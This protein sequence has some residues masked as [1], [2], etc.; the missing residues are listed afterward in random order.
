MI[1][2]LLDMLSKKVSKI[3]PYIR[4]VKKIFAFTFLFSGFQAAAQNVQESFWF[5]SF[6]TIRLSAKTSLH[7][8]FQLRT[9]DNAAAIQTLLPR[10]GFNWHVRKNHVLTAGYAYI[11]NRAVINGEGTL[12]GEHRLWQQY[13]INQT[14]KRNV[15]LQHRFRLEERWVPIAVSN[16]GSIEKDGFAFSTRLRYFARGIFP[17]QQHSGGFRRGVFAALQ[18]EIFVNTTNRSNVNGKFFD[19][20]RLYLAVGYRVSAKFDIE[21]GYLNQYINTRKGVNNLANHIW[22]IALYSR[23]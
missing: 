4:C 16:N 20:N 8:E 1:C 12:L 21:T 11:P 23:L 5:A 6:N 17:L 18:N 2:K 13:I 15:T 19:Q 22:Q 9:T 7:A 10:V 14:L 3:W